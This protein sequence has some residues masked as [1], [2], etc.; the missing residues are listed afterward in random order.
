MKTEVF[1]QASID[2]KRIEKAIQFIAENEIRSREYCR[3][4]L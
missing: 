1:S 3:Q 4:F 2:Y